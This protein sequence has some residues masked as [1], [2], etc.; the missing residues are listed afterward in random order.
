M[1]PKF[2]EIIQEKYQLFWR[3][4]YFYF[5]KKFSYFPFIGETDLDPATWKCS[6]CT[7]GLYKC[8]ICQESEGTVMKC[9]M[10]FCGRYFHEHCLLKHGLWPQ[11]RMAGD[12]ILSCPAHTCHTCASD[13]PKD[14]YMKYNSKYLKCIRCPTAYHSN[15]FCV[16]AGKV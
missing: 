6:Q 11:S 1:C 14:P 4:F 2:V 8:Q 3:K 7:N 5:I 13:N 10:N 15:D 16:A 9:Q 12:K